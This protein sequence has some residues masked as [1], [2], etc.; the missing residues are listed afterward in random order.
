MGAKA[1]DVMRMVIGDA[2]WMV[3]AGVAIG[4]PC[5][6][7]VAKVLNSALFQLKPLDPSTASL[8]TVALVAT[9]L[10]AAWLPARRAAATEPVA[11]LREE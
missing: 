2:L 5:A 9:T 1:G 7:A 8:S 4:L 6:Y 10:P 3:G 11:A